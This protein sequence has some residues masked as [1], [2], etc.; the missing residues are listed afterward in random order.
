MFDRLKDCYYYTY[1]MFKLQIHTSSNF[2]CGFFAISIDSLRQQSFCEQ[3]PA[4][5]QCPHIGDRYFKAVEATP[6]GEGALRDNLA[7]VT[8]QICAAVFY[9]L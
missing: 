2:I 7:T 3:T 6:M 1:F 9:R 4:Y 5:R 8:R